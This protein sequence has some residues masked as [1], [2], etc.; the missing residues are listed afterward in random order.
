MIARFSV[1]WTITSKVFLS[2]VWLYVWF[3]LYMH[4]HYQEI[5]QL[6][7]KSILYSFGEYFFWIS[8]LEMPSHVVCIL[9][10]K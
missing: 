7:L 8:Q 6:T 10:Q 1:E 5:T 2:N 9:Y 3:A 4:V